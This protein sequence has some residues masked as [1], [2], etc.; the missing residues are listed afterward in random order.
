MPDQFCKIFESKDFGQ[1]LVIKDSNEDGNPA[2]SVK[3]I[4]DGFG[5]CG[6][7]YAFTDEDEYVAW[8]KVDK[9]FDGIDL[10]K[11]ESIAKE[12]SEMTS[13]MR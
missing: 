8:E 13:A 3:F 9:L 2:V 4:P 10:G 5:L 7:D 6:P 11:A 12:I 1:I